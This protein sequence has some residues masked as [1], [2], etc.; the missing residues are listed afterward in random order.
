MAPLSPEATALLGRLLE[1]EADTDGI[2]AEASVWEEV[3][4]AFPVPLCDECAFCE[5][6]SPVEL[7]H[8]QM[9]GAYLRTAADVAAHAPAEGASVNNHILT[10][11]AIGD[12]LRPY[13]AGEGI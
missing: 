3:R 2:T 13:R 12:A 6:P 10:R 9:C 5:A 11:D 8:C 7:T 1:F 4:A